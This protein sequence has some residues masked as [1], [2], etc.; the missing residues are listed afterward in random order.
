[1]RVSDGTDVDQKRKETERTFH[2]QRFGGEQDHRESLNR[3]YAA[4]APCIRKQ[5][6]LIRRHGRGR[7]VL[8]YGCADGRI[9][10]A[11]DRLAHDS[12]SFHGIDISDQAI[13]RAQRNAAAQR[14][15]HCKFLVMDAEQMTFPDGAFDL[16]FGRGILHH[17]DLERSLPEI[18]RVLRPGGKAIFVEPLGHNPVLNRFRDKTPHLRTPDEHPLLRGDLRLARQHFQQMECTYFGFGTVLAVPFQNMSIGPGLMTFLEQADGLLLRLPLIQQHA[19]SVLITG[20]K[21]L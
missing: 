15:T 16:V 9:S 18:V 14:L 2:N 6:E 5:N 10:L 1:M 3:W 20:S 17:L 12:A 21:R 11:H 8:E 19:W 13:D 4:L 7:R